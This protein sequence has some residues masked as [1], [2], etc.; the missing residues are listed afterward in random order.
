MRLQLLEEYYFP[1]MSRTI[2][3]QLSS[4][5]CCK[6]Y[7][8]ERHLNKPLLQP[9]PVP[10]YPCEILHIFLCTLEKKIYLSCIEKFT[11]FKKLFPLEAKSSIHLREKLVEVLHSFA[12]PKVLVFDKERGLLCP[13][14]LTHARYRRLKSMVKSRGFIQ[15][16][17]RF[18][19]V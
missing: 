18:T 2:R 10:S 14:V 7:K 4:C 12:V 19:G 9:T 13:K 5:E 3:K 8:H 6:L 16:S 11:K 1:E 15:P 17:S